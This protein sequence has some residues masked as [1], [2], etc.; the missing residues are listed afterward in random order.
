VLAE[1]HDHDH[2]AD[3]HDDDPTDVHDDPTIRF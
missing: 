1:E 2:R 3:V